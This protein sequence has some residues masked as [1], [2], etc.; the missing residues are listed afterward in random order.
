VRLITRNIAGHPVNKYL[1]PMED[2]VLTVRGHPAVLIGPVGIAL[3][4]LIVAVLLS[5]TITGGGNVILVIWIAWGLLMLGL[6]VKVAYWFSTGYAVTQQRVLQAKGF[7]FPKVWMMPLKKV[8]DVTFQRSARGR[9]FDYGKLVVKFGFEQELWDEWS[10]EFVPHP[11]Q[12]YAKVR[13]VLFPDY[14]KGDD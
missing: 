10:M 4:G 13:R 9:H 12:A 1:L 2:V 3:A 8:T 5:A 14:D 6:I 11:E 7:L